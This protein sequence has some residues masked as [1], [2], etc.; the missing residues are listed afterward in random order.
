MERVKLSEATKDV[1]RRKEGLADFVNYIVHHADPELSYFCLALNYDEMDE[2]TKSHLLGIIVNDKT[3]RASEVSL[4][5]ICDQSRL[6]VD[7]R[8]ALLGKIV[9]QADKTTCSL[10]LTLVPN[11]GPW[12]AK[13]QAVFS[14]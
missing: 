5:L 11:L 9:E 8:D 12:E 1:S 7:E 13:L 10:A 4:R 6:D 2:T 3:N 14:H